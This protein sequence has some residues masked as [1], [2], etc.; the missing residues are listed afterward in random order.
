VF[1][2]ASAT[3]TKAW[4]WHPY[5]ALAF[6]CSLVALGA[7]PSFLLG[8]VA[9]VAVGGFAA[10]FQSLNNSLTIQLT[11]HEYHGRV[12]STSMLSWSLF[13]L[14]ALPIGVLADHIGIRETLA[15]MGAGCM[16]MLAVLTVVARARHAADDRFP[17]PVG[18]E[19]GVAGGR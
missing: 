15:I 8:L 2:A 14:I 4:S 3:S 19:V 11:D 12:Q 9:M 10:A 18:H 13:G 7:A 5:L 16:V 6:A 17:S 1:V